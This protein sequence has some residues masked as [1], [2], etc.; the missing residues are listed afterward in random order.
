V[1][2]RVEFP[3]FADKLSIDPRL[4]EYVYALVQARED[5]DLQE[6]SPVRLPAT[7]RPEIEHLAS[8]FADKSA[9]LDVMLDKHDQDDKQESREVREAYANALLNYL[10]K[11]SHVP[12]IPRD[13]VHL[14]AG[15]AAYGLEPVVA[16]DIEYAAVDR[17]VDAVRE[18]MDALAA[19]D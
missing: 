2:L 4:P 13:L 5:D 1:C 3:L 8:Q 10:R 14:E 12:P 7:V 11:T 9:P 19:L 17:N 15:G 6:G 16:D 18:T